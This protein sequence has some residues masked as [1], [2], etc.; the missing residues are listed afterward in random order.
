MPV[1]SGALTPPSTRRLARLYDLLGRRHD[2]AERYEARAKALALEALRLAP[3]QWVLDVGAGTGIEHRAIVRALG[4]GG[5]AVALDVSPVMLRLVRARTGSPVVLG[6]GRRLPFADAAFDRLLCCYVLD[7]LPEGDQRATVEE[8]ARVVRPGGLLALVAMRRGITP[9]SR[10]LVGAWQTLYRVSPLLVGG[11]R[12][13]A[14]AALVDQL[15][16]QV[17]REEST[18]QL[19]VPSQV[20]IL[21]RP[22]A[23]SRPQ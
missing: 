18:V 7:L 15:D 21:R 3:G 16:L 4:S 9:G 6:D 1:R 12:P 22:S 19:G 13:V 17:E 23:P 8:F 10:L 5:S 2:W 14:L 20:L 11:C